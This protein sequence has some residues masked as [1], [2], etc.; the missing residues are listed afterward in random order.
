MSGFHDIVWN[1][2][3]GEVVRVTAVPGAVVEFDG[4]PRD[5]LYP[6]IPI[7][8]RPRLAVVTYALN[9]AGFEVEAGLTWEWPGADARLSAQTRTLEKLY[10]T[11]GPAGVRV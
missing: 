6:G 9:Q 7:P 10:P 1:T 5:L 8:P 2:R 4:D 3:T 11:L